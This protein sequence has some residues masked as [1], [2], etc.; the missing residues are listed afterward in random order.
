MRAISYAKLFRQTGWHN[1]GKNYRGN[2]RFSD[3]IAECDGIIHYF[4]SKTL[5]LRTRL[6]A[7][8]R[9]KYSP[10]ANFAARH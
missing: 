6:P 10:L 1:W 9:T 7:R 5:M 3:A 4:C 8:R 2:L